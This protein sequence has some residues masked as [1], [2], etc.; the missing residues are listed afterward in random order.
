MNLIEYGFILMLHP[1]CCKNQQEMGIQE[2][3]SIC[4]HK[5]FGADSLY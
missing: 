3:V 1:D 5:Q 2:H 4:Q